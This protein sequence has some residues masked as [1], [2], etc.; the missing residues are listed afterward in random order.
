M[1]RLEKFLWLNV[2]TCAASSFAASGATFGAASRAPAL[3][4]TLITY[5]YTT[6]SSL[7]QNL[8][9]NEQILFTSATSCFAASCAAFG[10][11]SRALALSSTLVTYRYMRKSNLVASS[12]TSQ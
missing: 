9:K 7:V 8:M 2:F 1:I 5:K 4:S 11:A 6:E 10:A 3:S 12:V